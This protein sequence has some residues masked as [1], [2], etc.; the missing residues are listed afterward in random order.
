MSLQG[1]VDVSEKDDFPDVGIDTTHSFQAI[2]YKLEV[3]TDDH[4]MVSIKPV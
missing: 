1:A 2:Q 3:E 4:G